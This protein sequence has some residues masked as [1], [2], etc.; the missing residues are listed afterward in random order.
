MYFD[1]KHNVIAKKTKDDNLSMKF[2][3]ILMN[4]ESTATLKPHFEVQY[5]ESLMRT[6]DYGRCHSP[7]TEVAPHTNNNF[8]LRTIGKRRHHK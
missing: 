1:G 2:E 8:L 7:R 5:P 3:K 4:V 6:M